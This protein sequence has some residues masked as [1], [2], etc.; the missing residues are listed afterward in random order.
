MIA[1]QVI[2][3]NVRLLYQKQFGWWVRRLQAP[4]IHKTSASTR[5]L[6]AIINGAST[7]CHPII[8]AFACYKRTHDP[9]D[10]FALYR[11]LNNIRS[12]TDSDQSS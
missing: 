7:L 10:R 6:K 4:G 3:L 9:A 1:A 12:S 2:G 8:A 5:P 11:E